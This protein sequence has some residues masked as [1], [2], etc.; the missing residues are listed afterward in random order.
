MK[1]NVLG[2]AFVLRK[3]SL[4]I[5]LFEVT[6]SESP[7]MH[8][9]AVLIQNPS[10]SQS[11]DSIDSVYIQLILQ[12]FVCVC[13]CTDDSSDHVQCSYTFVHAFDSPKIQIKLF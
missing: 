10:I 11:I 13:V 2:K 1:F 8:N 3:F 9:C 4:E 5:K 6:C 7:R 12:K